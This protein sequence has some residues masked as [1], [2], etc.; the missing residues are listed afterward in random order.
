MET[1][2]KPRV[3]SGMRPTGALHLG[4]LTGALDNWVRL[5]DTYDCFYSVVDYHAL[6]TEYED[7]S[8]IRQNV[9]E[10]AL[11][12][13]AAGI[14]PERSCVFIQSLVPEHAELHLLLSMTTPVSWLERVPTYK[15]VQANMGHKDLATYGFLGYPL[16]QTADIIIYKAN[17]VPVGEDQAPHIEISR[18]IVRRF[19]NFYGPVFPEPQ[20]L[21]T[22][23]PRTPGTDGRKMSKSYNNSILLKDTEGEIRAKLKTMVTD[24]ARQRKTDKG[25]PTKC[26]V[27]D[28]HKAFSTQETRDWATAGCT[29][30]SIGC[31]ECKTRL[32]DHV[33]A[34]I[35]PMRQKREELAARPDT[36]MDILKD[37]SAR[38][39]KVAQATMDEVH[40]AMKIAY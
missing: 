33:V 19:N 12:W 10:V 16:L 35:E 28:L 27:F 1:K 24:P 34:R 23:V 29:S 31:I 25:D 7:P 3:L 13:L 8:G 22:P 21:L 2:P 18:E 20:T 5:Q 40:K 39:R 30:A 32:A 9:I 37:G 17:A 36:V 38:A 6:T 15:D 11:D 4:H 26:P 14:D